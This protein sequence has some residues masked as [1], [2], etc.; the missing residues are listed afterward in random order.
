MKSSASEFLFT[1]KNV[2]PALVFLL[3]RRQIDEELWPRM[4]EEGMYTIMRDELWAVYLAEKLYAQHGN[5]RRLTINKRVRDI[6][7]ALQT[8]DYSQLALW[9]KEHE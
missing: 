8:G 2:S 5:P 3:L 1:E 4:Q 6:G 7:E 9:R